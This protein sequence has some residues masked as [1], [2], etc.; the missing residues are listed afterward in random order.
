MTSPTHCTFSVLLCAV[1]FS[2][3]SVAFVSDKPAIGFALLGSL[4]PDLDTPKSAIGRIL[5][6][7]S[8]PLEK[9]F[10]HRGLLHSFLGLLIFAGIASPLLLVKPLY[11]YSFLLG[12][13]SHI[14]LDCVNVSGVALFHPLPNIC[15]FP[16]SDN[17]RIK[18]GSLKGEGIL[19]IVLII[20]L[21][22]YMPVSNLGLFRAVRYL[23]ASQ[24]GAYTDYNNINNQASIL[25]YTAISTYS[26]KKIKDKSLIISANR[27]HFLVW[28]DGEILK[29]GNDDRCDYVLKK[30]RTKAI[31]QEIDIRKINCTAKA[32]SDLIDLEKDFIILKGELQGSCDFILNS[33]GSSVKKNHRTLS[34]EFCPKSD[35]TSIEIEK[36]AT[37]SEELQDQFFLADLEYN[38]LLNRKK[39]YITAKSKLDS[40]LAARKQILDHASSPY[41]I[42]ISRQT[43]EIK[44]LRSTLNSIKINDAYHIQLKKKEFELE[45]IRT[46]LK[47][48]NKK[49]HFSGYLKIR[50]L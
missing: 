14:L 40:I 34:F 29:L 16:Y 10:G 23:T 2:L 1:I 35:F 7:I 38:N 46:K 30:C 4:F 27:Y 37:G 47:G 19:L 41:S 36:N 39:K 15:V 3:T 12:Y 31:D 6:F 8:T 45:K 43:E 24:Q 26:R 9:K 33:P 50:I 11:Y 44:N 20:L 17:Y 48:Y 5:F 21:A 13:F 22:L 18:T 49:L 42:E 28:E 32:F 25:D